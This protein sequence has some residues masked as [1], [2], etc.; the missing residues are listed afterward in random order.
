MNSIER[1]LRDAY[2]GAAGTVRPD[3]I[4]PFGGAMRPH[5]GR[6]EAPYRPGVRHLLMPLSAAVAVAL[7]VVLVAV[8]VPRVLSGD[9]LA[10]K[11]G[12]ASGAGPAGRYLVAGVGPH[13]GRQHGR[14]LSVRSV[15]TGASSGT[16]RAPAG[17]TI[18]NVAT[19]DG[20]TYVVAMI[21]PHHCRTW[22]YQFRLNAAGRPGPL[23]RYALPSVDEELGAIALSRSDSTFA[24]WGYRC[25]DT[26]GRLVTARV[27]GGQRGSAQWTLPGR[28][29]IAA[30]SLTADGR[31]LGFSTN[32]VRNE[33][34]A[35]YVLRS[36]APAGPALQRAQRVATAKQFGR[37]L[38]TASVI[39]ADG[40]TMYFTT[41][42]AGR[43]AGRSWQLRA[44]DV[45]SGR[46]ALIGTYRGAPWFLSASPRVSRLLVT[47]ALR[48]GPA[49]SPTPSPSS[50]RPAPSAYASPSRPYPSAAPSPSPGTATAH[51]SGSPV[52]SPGPGGGGR[53]Q[54]RVE[55]F[56]LN[57]GAVSVRHWQDW[58]RLELIRYAW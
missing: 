11:P 38:I 1:Q 25:N 2:R 52:P 46:I 27:S 53:L 3:S 50:P 19:G 41:M 39:A 4:R 30:L 43:A 35:A 37:D 28:T 7:V 34:S 44:A 23:V 33:T 58:P 8:V 36:S 49:P 14:E 51:P 48:T 32:R 54:Y 5:P 21:R 29:P 12:P 47:V 42:P 57:S 6:P 45:G 56:R 20:R 55:E 9:R 24:F 16:V 22:L 26:E 18:D 13:G 31:T 10:G 17:L 40:R 15:T